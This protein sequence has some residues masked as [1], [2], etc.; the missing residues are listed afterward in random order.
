LMLTCYY[1]MLIDAYLIF[2]RWNFIFK[3]EYYLIM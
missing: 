3:C 2:T 1:K